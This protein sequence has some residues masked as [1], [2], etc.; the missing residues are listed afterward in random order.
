[1]DNHPSHQDL[2]QVQQKYAADIAKAKIEHWSNFLENANT[3]DIWSVNKYL[4]NPPGNGGQ[5]RIPML[6][7]KGNNG[8]PREVNTNKGKANILSEAFF[9]L[10]LAASTVPQAHKYPDLL[11]P[12]AP[13]TQEQIH[14]HITKLSPYRVPGPDSIPNIV[15]QKSEN[16]IVP[17][18]LPIYRSML[19]KWDILSQLARIHDM[20][21]EKTQETKL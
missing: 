1:V 16:L 13:V 7:V 5:T 20:H 12:P 3:T 21:T 19:K 18:L 11:P 6:K 9:P 14:V 15:L 4:M 2:C 17:Y 10:K 8:I